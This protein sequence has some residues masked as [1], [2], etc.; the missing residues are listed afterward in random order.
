[1]GGDGVYRCFT[2]VTGNIHPDLPPR[3]IEYGNEKV[4]EL[5]S[6]SSS[7]PASNPSSSSASTNSSN[8]TAANV[9]V[10]CTKFSSL[11]NICTD[12]ISDGLETWIYTRFETI[13]MS[14][15]VVSKDSLVKPVVEV[16]LENAVTFTG[17]LVYSEPTNK[18]LQ[19]MV[20]RPLPSAPQDSSSTLQMVDAVLYSVIN[21][22]TTSLIAGC[23]QRTP[24]STFACYRTGVDKN[25]V[26]RIGR[27]SVNILDVLKA[28]KVTG[29]AARAQGDT[30]TTYFQPEC[31]GVTNGSCAQELT[32]SEGLVV[33][34]RM[35]RP[36]PVNV[37]RRVILRS[38]S[39]CEGMTA[40][41]C[42][43][44][45]LRTTR[46]DTLFGGVVPFP[47]G[48]EGNATASI[49]A[50]ASSVAAGG[51][52][53]AS[54]GESASSVPTGGNATASQDMNASADNGA[55]AGAPIAGEYIFPVHKR[56]IVII[57]S[58]GQ[59]VEM[60]LVNK[61]AGSIIT[62][63][64]DVEGDI[65]FPATIE[66]TYDGEEHSCIPSHHP[67]IHTLFRVRVKRDEPAYLPSER[68][69]MHAAEPTKSPDQLDLELAIFRVPLP[70]EEQ[71]VATLR[72]GEGG[73]YPEGDESR[74][75]VAHWERGEEGGGLP[76]NASAEG[77]GEAAGES[78]GQGEG[79]ARR[80][81]NSTLA[82]TASTPEGATSEPRRQYLCPNLASSGVPNPV[83]KSFGWDEWRLRDRRDFEVCAFTLPSLALTLN[84]LNPEAS[85]HLPLLRLAHAATWFSSCTVAMFLVSCCDCAGVSSFP[86]FPFSSCPWLRVSAPHHASFRVRGLFL[87]TTSRS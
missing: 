52:A 12:H 30:G 68:H 21:F 45:Q 79:G 54:L 6:A 53:T 57:R 18:A 71:K 22:E 77:H 80:Q 86:L 20:L 14:F 43:K 36:M 42:P 41:H 24:S 4:A 19:F 38:F 7:G 46:Q 17:Q 59:V 50:N 35:T 39:L 84:P 25:F 64:S 15:P 28:S 2:Q 1:M 48:D 56:P 29:I 8:G 78:R 13:G 49:D 82:P 40:S 60:R 74:R 61:T 73:N 3:L 65:D 44:Y 76:D 72:R 34:L 9:T 58:R 62:L 27:D 83:I 63:D 47:Y 31:G 87:T 70:F 55:A 11:W 85:L 67:C 23:S 10:A 75:F 66:T 32:G 5:R 33:D 16:L 81:G 51:N 37:G 26:T 69:L